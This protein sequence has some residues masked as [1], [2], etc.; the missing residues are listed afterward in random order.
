MPAVRGIHCSFNICCVHLTFSC[1]S[2]VGPVS[3]VGQHNTRTR[4]PREF[5]TNCL[6]CSCRPD[7]K[8]LFR[9]AVLRKQGWAVLAIPW[10]E[11]LE[12]VSAGQKFGYLDN[13][14]KRA[15]TEHRQ[16]SETAV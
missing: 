12:L 1:I 2:D 10:F 16:A 6:Y 3:V 13:K 14:I 4:K 7:G 5:G 15:V 11:W 9:N 8:T